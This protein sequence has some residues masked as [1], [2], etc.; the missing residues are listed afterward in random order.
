PEF[1]EYAKQTIKNAQAMADEFMKRGYKIIS[2]GTD[3][4]L[5][6]IDMTSKE[7]TGKEAETIFD[8]IGVS[9]SRS[10]IP[11]DSNPP[12]NPSGVRLG[13]PAITT[14]GLKEAEVRK[15]AEWMDLA[16]QN[17]ENIETLEDIKK[18]VEGVCR[19]FPVPGI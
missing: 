8:R 10:T 12:M 16:I 9:V 1:K 15:L 18:E 11:N 17:R 14:R 4:H 5:F 19:E 6:V 2:D 7:V 13:T 3:N